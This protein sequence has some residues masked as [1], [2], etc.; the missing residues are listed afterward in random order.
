MKLF[1]SWSGEESHAIALVLRE[2]LRCVIQSIN[3]FVSSEDI[4]K[5]TPWFQK[6]ATELEDSEFGIICLTKANQNNKWVLFE[7]GA[8]AGRFSRAKVAPLLIDVKESDVT[9]PLGQFQLTNLA[10]K[11]DF[12][13]LLKSINAVLKDKA[14]S[15]EVLKK[16]F[17]NWWDA[18]SKRIKETLAKVPKKSQDEP[19]RTDRALLEEILSLVRSN[20]SS[21][22]PNPW[23]TLTDA[24]TSTNMSP[25]A[26]TPI[27]RTLVGAPTRVSQRAIPISEYLS[28]EPSPK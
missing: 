4:E 27:A 1:I 8:L 23:H 10:N 26:G 3:P 14:L 16:S 21:N 5:G 9:P 25:W 12:L 2:E 7:A 28:D 24:L 11:D 22:T 19:E 18:F 15:E 6:I 13:K 20:P 17:D